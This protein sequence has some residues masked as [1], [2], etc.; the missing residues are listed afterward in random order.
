[1]NPFNQCSKWEKCNAPLCPIDPNWQKTRHLK[2]EAVCHWLRMY[3]KNPQDGR[4]QGI[5]RHEMAHQVISVYD[6]AIVPY[7][8]L[9]TALERAALTGSRL[10]N[11][12]VSA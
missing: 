1:M 2:G 11:L 10:D 9:R 4:F 7:G 3:A 8:A 6:S 5:L 12:G